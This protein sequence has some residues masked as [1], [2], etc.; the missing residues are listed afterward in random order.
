MGID[1]PIRLLGISLSNLYEQEGQQISLFKTARKKEQ[2]TR[3]MDAVNN[4]LG[5]FR[6]TFGSLLDEKEKGSHVIS[7]AWRPEG[8]RNVGV[9]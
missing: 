8:I 2:L 4:K 3:A 1:Q 9:E 5:D 6:V 7:P